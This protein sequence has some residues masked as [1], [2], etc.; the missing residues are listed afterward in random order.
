[1]V[2][3]ARFISC[4]VVTNESCESPNGGQTCGKPLSPQVVS[5][6]VNS[7]FLFLVSL[8]SLLIASFPLSL[9]LCL[10]CYWWLML[11]LTVL[12]HLLYVLYVLLGLL[13]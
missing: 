4:R 5:F 7:F 2:R 8:H 12:T 13:R 1:M 9:L 11:L 6:F 10:R 3:S